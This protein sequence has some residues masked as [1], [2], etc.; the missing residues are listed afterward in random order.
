[1]PRRTF[2]Y[3]SLKKE[4][5]V[6]E[7]IA[8]RIKQFIEQYPEAG[9]RTVAWMLKLNKN[10]VQRIFQLK[11]WQVKKKARGLRP[12]IKAFP[13]AAP[14]PKP[15]LVNRFSARM[16]W[17]RSMVHVSTGDRLLHTRDFRMATESKW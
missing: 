5:A 2:Y 14:S 1:M 15:A 12:R 6:N 9:Y 13:S 3:Q 11:G 10:T 8:M 7:V 17:S 4:P 16:V